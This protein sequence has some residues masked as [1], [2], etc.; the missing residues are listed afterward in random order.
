MAKMTRPEVM[1]VLENDKNFAGLDLSGM[2]FTGANFERANWRAAALGIRQ[3]VT[4]I[5]QALN[6]S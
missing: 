6:H 3:A 2:D 5:K 4:L 1:T